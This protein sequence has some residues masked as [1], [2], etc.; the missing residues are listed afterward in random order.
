MKRVL[1]LLAGMLLSG[2]ASA[3]SFVGLNY[4]VPEQDDRFFG[5]G[6][7]FDTGD[8]F[9]RL[10]AEMNDIFVSELRAGAT[11][12]PNEENNLSFEH[13]YMYGGYLRA[14]YK[15]GPLVP[16]VIAGVT[17]GKESLEA[18]S[19]VRFTEK[20]DDISYGAGLDLRV[21]DH[22]GLNAEFTRYYD[23]GNVMLRGPSAG[24]F[25]RF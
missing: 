25:F 11:V 9:I 16:Y 2:L 19:G 8:V 23:I 4:A 14:Q 17:A 21:G 15:L 10:G 3:E 18:N 13:D 22:L 12:S 24:I 6:D 5:S 1:L 7:R 20:F